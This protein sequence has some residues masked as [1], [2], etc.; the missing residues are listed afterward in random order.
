MNNKTSD[1][2]LFF[3]VSLFIGMFVVLRILSNE[4]E[5]SKEMIPYMMQTQLLRP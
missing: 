3:V 2:V 1:F 4:E 5:N